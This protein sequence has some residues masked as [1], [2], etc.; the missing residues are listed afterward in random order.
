VSTAVALDG[1]KPH[2]PRSRKGVR[3]RA[4]LLEAAKEVFEEKGFFATRIADIAE[5]AGLSRGSVHH[6]FES[7][8]QIFREVVDAVYERFSAGM[9]DVILAPSSNATPPERLRLAIRAYLDSYLEEARIIAVV[10]QVAR[11]DEHVAQVEL[12]RHR[13]Y[14]EQVAGSIRRLQR[15]GMADR[16]LDPTVAAAALGALTDRFAELWLTQGLLDI[17]LD[18]GAEQLTRLFVNAL[19]LQPEA[20]SARRRALRAT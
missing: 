1:D 6:Y 18:E 8:E 12:A 19:G 2:G 7:K 17:G 5:R 15:R 3:T 4:R 16:G 11:F 10:Q 14:D 13:H 20:T 9:T